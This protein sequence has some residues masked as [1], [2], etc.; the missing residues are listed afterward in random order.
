MNIGGS[1]TSDRC[2]VR[3]AA[4][5]VVL[6]AMLGCS[7]GDR[8]AAPSG[9][10]G[11]GSDTVG[12]VRRGTLAVDLSIDVA[13]SLIASAVGLSVSGPHDVTVILEGGETS[14]TARSNANG[15][16]RFDGL[17]EGTYVL[18]AERLVTAAERARLLPAD[19]DVTGLAGGLRVTVQPGNNG[20]QL[21]L[22]AGRQGSLVISEIWPYNPRTIANDDTYA[23]GTFLEVVNNGDTAVYLDG[24]VLGL[25]PPVHDNIGSVPPNPDRCAAYAE[26]RTNPAELAAATIFAFPGRGDEFLLPP[27]AAVVIAQDAIDHR[28][29]APAALDLS[30]SDFELIGD[31]RDV[32]NP[33]VPNMIRVRGGV[34]AYGRGLSPRFMA[35][36]TVFLAKAPSTAYRRATVDAGTSWGVDLPFV[37]RADVLDVA[38]FTTTAS[39][40]ALLASTGLP[41]ED[42]SPWIAPI[43]DRAPAPINDANLHNTLASGFVRRTAYVRTD[44]RVVL[45]RTRTSVRDWTYGPSATPGVVR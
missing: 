28:P 25:V 9:G 16:V 11:A 18:S 13:D 3:C 19:L 33:A 21:S 12:T 2:R 7:G 26:V 39:A 36:G 27:G 38:A 40:R 43:W 4:A 41:I 24:V 6:S 10:S 37:P 20:A 5:S 17:I 22:V 31:T 15:R 35:N 1:W 44:G 45:Q 14:R 30:R 8:V 29:F 32:D 42:C 34:G 23:D